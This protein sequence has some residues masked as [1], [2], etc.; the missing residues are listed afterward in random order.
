MKKILKENKEKII[1]II[2]AFIISL[3]ATSS[4]LNATNYLTNDVSV[5]TV[6]A[7]MMQEGRI[8]YS[9]IFD[10]KGPI[11]YIIYFIGYAIGS[12]N[13]IWL[14]DFICMVINSLAIYSIAKKFIKSNKTSVIATIVAMLGICILYDENPGA[15]SIALPFIFIA[16]NK[17]IDFVLDYNKFGKKESIITGICLGL[18][19]FI[20]PN[21]V[22]LWVVYDLYIF[23]KLIKEKEV[24]KLINIILYSLLGLGIVALPIIAFFACNNALKDFFDTYIIFNL[25]Y[26]SGIKVNL[27]DVIT[28]FVITFITRTKGLMIYIFATHIIAREYLLSDKK[29]NKNEI[30]LITINFIFYVLSMYLVLSPIRVYIHY[31]NILI[32]TAIIPLV[33]CCKNIEISNKVHNVLI[34]LSVIYVAVLLMGDSM[35]WSNYQTSRYDNIVAQAKIVENITNKEDNVLQLGN[36][37]AFYI[38]S[39]RTYKGKYFYQDPII[40]YDSKIQEEFM[41]ELSTNLPKVI[42]D[43]WGRYVENS[44][45]WKP[46]RKILDENYIRLENDIYVLKEN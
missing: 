2:M 16:L 42:V 31:A 29:D 18:A 32:P 25:K 1:L 4:I 41:E 34:M 30:N 24:K 35:T 14:I 45:F 27:W 36:V 39:D 11:L 23:F 8:V 33:I 17:F 19:L 9:Q 12:K 28:T 37:T 10:H 40:R 20:R 38:L 15:E 3:R 5:W 21:L 26:A 44:E 13:G 46:I 7:K 22:A 43:Y 6:L